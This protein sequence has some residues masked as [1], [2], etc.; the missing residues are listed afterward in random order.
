MA[1]VVSRE[2]LAR[3]LDELAVNLHRVRAQTKVRRERHRVVPAPGV[4]FDETRRRRSILCERADDVAQVI[5]RLFR[6]V[7][8]RVTKR[9]F[10]MLENDGSFP[11]RRRRRRLFKDVIAPPDDQMRRRLLPLP[12]HPHHRGFDR[13]HPRRHSAP[14][15]LVVVAKPIAIV[16]RAHD[17]FR[18][19]SI[20]QYARRAHRRRHVVIILL[21]LLH[22]RDRTQKRIDTSTHTLALFPHDAS[23]I[24]HIHQFPSIRRRRHQTH[25]RQSRRASPNSSFLLFAPVRRRRVDNPETRPRAVS[26]N[27]RRR[28]RL[29]VFKR[30]ALRRRIKG[31]RHQVY[32]FFKQM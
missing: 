10:S 19:R 24:E 20:T 27:P 12:N 32:F 26:I 30:L 17:D 28:E 31:L 9:P 14:R 5:R 13:H 15:R 21:F 23:R 16:R 1:H 4:Q 25:R 7:R 3:R 22:T 11:E 2:I 8:V 29:Q 6:H 18:R